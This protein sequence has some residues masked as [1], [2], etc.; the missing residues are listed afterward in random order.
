MDEL[1]GQDAAR[2]GGLSQLKAEVRLQ[3]AFRRMR[4]TTRAQA[5]RN[6]AVRGGYR[7]IPEPIRKVMY[8]RIIARGFKKGL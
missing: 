5:L 7:L 1:D 4:F 8:R 2:R 3:R 6:V